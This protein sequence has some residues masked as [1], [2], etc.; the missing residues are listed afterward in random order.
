MK[1]IVVQAPLTT[2][3][4]SFSEGTDHSWVAGK[5]KVI[6]AGKFKIY[7]ACPPEAPDPQFSVTHGSVSLDIERDP[8]R[9]IKDRQLIEYFYTPKH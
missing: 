4:I 8:E 3:L 5:M 2:E 6:S 7:P 1:Y 9:E